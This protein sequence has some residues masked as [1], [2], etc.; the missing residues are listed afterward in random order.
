[1]LNYKRQS[2]FILIVMLMTGLL[3]SC[4]SKIPLATPSAPGISVGIKDDLCPGVTVQAGQQVT[5]T[6]QGASEHVVRDITIEGSSQFD[7]GILKSGDTFSFTF[8]QAKKYT[9]ECSEDGLLM[10]VITVEP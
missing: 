6:N 10:G 9:Y 3:A 7:S 4:Q 2:V 8:L 1:M 5:W